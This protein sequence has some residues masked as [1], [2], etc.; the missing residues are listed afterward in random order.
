MTTASLQAPKRSGRL[1]EL[2]LL[3]FIAAFSVL[4]FHYSFRGYAKDHYTVV[5]YLWIAPVTKYGYLG[6]SLFFLISGFV[7][8]M[9]ASAGSTRHFVISR[10]VR[11]YPAFWVCCTCTFLVMLGVG[12]GKAPTLREYAV[13]LTMLNGFV[14]VRS[15]DAV[16]W[17]LFVELKFYAL[18]FLVLL[19]GQMGRVKALL[20]VWL[21]SYAVCTFWHVKYV[22]ALLIPEFAPYFIAG[23]FFF[24]IWQEGASL[25][26]GLM[27]AAC[28]AL[29]EVQSLRDTAEVATTYHTHM[30]ALAPAVALAAFFVVFFLI[31]TGRT[32]RWANRRFVLL[33]ALTY[34]LYLIHQNVGYALL[35]LGYGRINV[36]LLM[37]G[38]TALMLLAAY[39]VTRIERIAAPAMKD[40]LSRLLLPRRTPASP[41]PAPPAPQ[42]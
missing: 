19:L 21:A 32:R 13:N 34:P 11:L 1:Y 20:A 41:I 38:V 14:G 31:A 15:I 6:V 4:L 26:K 27:I 12:H 25:Y 5:P 39:G 40:V 17:S 23:A 8:L 28:L 9:T 18:V 7:I 35:N 22:S 33:G 42:Q 2:D 29:I 3:R 16:Y 10:L 37:W 24:L 36:H 30:N